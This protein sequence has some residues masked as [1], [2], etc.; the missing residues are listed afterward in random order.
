VLR[1]KTFLFFL[2]GLMAILCLAVPAWANGPTI[3]PVTPATVNINQEFDVNVEVRDV[4]GLQGVQFTLQFNPAVLE[5]RSINKGN[6]F[7]SPLE[8][9]KTFN[10]TTGL[11]NY[12]AIVLTT[13]EAFSGSSG[14]AAVIRFRS[15]AAG[16]SQLTIS[17]TILGA[18][19]GASIAHTAFSATVNVVQIVAPTVQTNAATGIT[20]NSATLNGNITNTG[21]EN[22]D[23][24]KF[25]YKQQGAASWI[26]TTVETGPFGTGA[27][28]FALTGLTPNTTYE[29]KAL[30][31]NTAGWGEGTV[32][33]FTTLT[34][35]G[36]TGGG[37]GGGVT[38]SKPE[39]DKY[40]PDKDAKDVALDAL[41]RVTFK[42]DIKAGDLTK[43]TI[44][45]D[46]N[47]EV[48]GVKA[49]V[50]GKALTIAHDKFSYETK[51]T[52]NVP[53]GTVKRADNNQE[54]DAISW[55]FTTLKE[56]VPPKPECVFTDMSAQHWAANV[57]KELCQ[58]G[59]IGGYPDG[60]FKP[61]ND[62]TRAEFTK[63]I[64]KALGLA[65]EN[66][67]APTFKDVAPGDWYFGVVEAAA[68]AG[69]VKG[70]EKGEFRPNAKITR[71]EIA[72]ILVRALGKQDA[73]AASANAKTAFKD[74]QSIASWARGSVVVAVQEGLI[75]GYPDG[76]FGP[77][78]NATRAETCAMV[79]RFLEKK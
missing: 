14:V 52:V 2:L 4:Q 42:Q 34:S 35:G 73:A 63:I 25:Q 21:G 29:V 28:S 65:E 48:T 12:G 43:V 58:K 50:S 1:K 6:I 39:V 76:T 61:G 5:A 64:V 38:P 24:R 54:N 77:K 79:S 72:A 41:V 55:S 3:G 46:K 70:Y 47:K 36:S 71:Q 56:P 23:Q 20:T 62:I 31:H 66:P 53:K 7:T 37:G 49:T 9:P 30:A 26:D 75:K 74:D 68:K 19:G 60:T 22:C 16:E 10:N 32:I 17:E 8:A 69:L 59:I 40:E 18:E 44:K 33:A 67:A 45:D 51:Y 57:I 78:K 13:A 11:V 27:F 15:K